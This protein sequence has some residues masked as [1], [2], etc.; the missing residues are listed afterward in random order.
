[1]GGLNSKIKSR[2][3]RKGEEIEGPPSSNVDG[4]WKREENTHKSRPTEI[5]NVIL[6]NS[7]FSARY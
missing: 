1:M 6:A 5:Y 7:L 2:G 4:K 3:R